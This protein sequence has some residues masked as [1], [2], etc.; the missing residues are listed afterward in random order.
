[1]QQQRKIL[2]VILVQSILCVSVCYYRRLNEIVNYWL[3]LNCTPEEFI[4]VCSITFYVE[5]CSELQNKAYHI[6]KRSQVCSIKAL[7]DERLEAKLIKV[8]VFFMFG[9]A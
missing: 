8:F 5:M 1:M 2:G 4:T 9:S 6:G 3:T 7:G